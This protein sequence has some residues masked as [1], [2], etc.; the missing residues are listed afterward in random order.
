MH[1]KY[2]CTFLKKSI[3]LCVLSSTYQ[4][5]NF[6]LIIRYYKYSCTVQIYLRMRSCAN[7]FAC[8]NCD[9]FCEKQSC[10]INYFPNL[11]EKLIYVFVI[12][13]ISIFEDVTLLST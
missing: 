3:S 6:I 2:K 10:I 11:V 4:T 12:D 9:A 7:V 13:S 5:R 8:V 1:I